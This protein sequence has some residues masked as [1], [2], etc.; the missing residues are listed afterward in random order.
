MGAVRGPK[1]GGCALKARRVLDGAFWTFLVAPKIK[2]TFEKCKASWP[3]PG[4][5]E[6]TT[7]GVLGD[8]PL[9]S[10]SCAGRPPS[11]PSFSRSSSTLGWVGVVTAFW[12]PVAGI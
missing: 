7:A 12:T 4:L 1:P 6:G 2:Q 9:A 5:L 3:S 10:S 8:G 11:P